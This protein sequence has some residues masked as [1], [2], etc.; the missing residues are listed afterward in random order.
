MILKFQYFGHLMQRIDS[1]EKTLMLRKIKDRRRRGW[2]KMRWLDGITDSQWT[3]VWATS[4]I[5]WW[6]GKPG[7]LQSMV[8]HRAGHDWATELNGQLLYHTVS[9]LLC[10]KVHKTLFLSF[11]AHWG[12]DQHTFP[13]L[14]NRLSL[15]AYF[16]HTRVHLS[17]PASRFI[18]SPFLPWKPQLVLCV[19]DSVSEHK[20]VHLY[21]FSR[22][23]I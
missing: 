8:S 12:H 22:F 2:Q 20:Y 9:L 17:I 13:V 19:C 14:Y 1:L 23:N 7:V 6:T 15:V 21:C 10:S 11:P 4:R 18:P 5:W 16:I 3:W